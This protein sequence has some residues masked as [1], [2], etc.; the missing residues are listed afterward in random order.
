MVAGFSPAPKPATP[1]PM[2]A[3][4]IPASIRP[5]MPKAGVLTGGLSMLPLRMY[6]VC[7]LAYHMQNIV[8]RDPALV[9]ETPVHPPV[10]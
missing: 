8:C 3:R 10:L 4:P 1:T 7:I 2:V 5:P 9:T 6:T